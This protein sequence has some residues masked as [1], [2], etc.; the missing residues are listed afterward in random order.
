MSQRDELWTVLK[1][2]EWVQGYLAEKGE[3]N[4]RLAAQ[5]LLSAAT[6]L[7][8]VQLYT[9]FDQP[10]DGEQRQLLRGYCQ[11][12][13]TGEPLQYITGKA[14]FRHLELAVA[15]GVLIPRPETETLVQLVL[16]HLLSLPLPAG[17]SAAES[18]SESATE[19]TSEP[20]DGHLILDIGTGS[21]NIALALASES[22]G[23]RVLACD[24]SDD[25]L[26][27][28]RQNAKALRLADKVAFFWAD[29]RRQR[30][31]FRACLREYIEAETVLPSEQEKRTSAASVAK[32]ANA[33][34]EADVAEQAVGEFAVVVANLPYIPSALLNDLPHEVIDFEPRL[35][36]DGGA[37]GLDLVRKLITQAP[38]LLVPGGLLALEL[39]EDNAAQTAALLSNLAF[40]QIQLH[41][42]L[43]GNPRFVTASK[44]A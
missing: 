41:N 36:L 28:A 16:D 26:N 10:L 24:S 21:G 3:P 44:K 11:R 9:N 35:A 22:A 17:E 7:D 1:A 34:V 42:D 40:E 32:V 31:G 38:D 27:L 19:S 37:D 14:Y 13:A 15:T 18:T 5:W 12:R 20:T 30:D 8:R 33:V 29:L 25:A 43:N 23:C 2:L 6:G 4:P 39:H